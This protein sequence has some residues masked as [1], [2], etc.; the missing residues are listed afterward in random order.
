[1]NIDP[2]ALLV[3]MLDIESVTEREASL[4]RFLVRFMAANGFDAYLDE[5][6]NAVGVR[7]GAEAGTP[8]RELVLLGHMDTVPGVVPIRRDG[9]RLYGR[10]AVDAKGPLAAFVVAAAR[11]ALEPGA[12]V[13]VI[14]AVEEEGSSRGARFVAN[15]PAP[16]ACIIGEP[17]GWDAVTLGY[18][19]SLRVDFHDDRPCGHSAGPDGGIAESV[20]D[21]WHSVRARTRDANVGREALF[22]QLQC[23]LG[24]VRTS[25]D[26]LVDAVDATASFRIP[27]GLEPERVLDDV[28]ACAASGVVTCRGIEPP[29]RSERTT[30]LAPPFVRAL[31]AAGA[32][33]RFKVKTGTSDMN[34][35]GPAWGCPIVAYGPGD[36]RLDH[37]PDEHVSIAEYLRS[38]DVLQSVIEATTSAA[39]R[40]G[41]QRGTGEICDHR[42]D[43]A[44]G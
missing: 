5:A 6:G 7:E 28:V 19:G 32:A 41:G 12:R 29:Y 40:H 37:T 17:S 1:V 21:W 13:V 35:V 36:S 9:D 38:I 22:E 31:R 20:V 24:A 33:P 43:V 14:G 2:V 4:A 16:V 3:R 39:W 15:R 30:P 27:P 8:V 10:G 26:G 44:R 34:V 23:R 11:A 18:K 25:S 42:F